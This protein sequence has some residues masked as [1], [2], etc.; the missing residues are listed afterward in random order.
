VAGVGK[1][2]LLVVLLG[3]DGVENRENVQPDEGLIIAR[4]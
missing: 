4:D 2:T 3:D 1:V